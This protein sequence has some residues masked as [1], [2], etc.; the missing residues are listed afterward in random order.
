MTR[1][2]TKS[3]PKTVKFSLPSA[4]VERLRNAVHHLQGPPKLLRMNS[5][6]TEALEAYVGELEEE[7]GGPFPRRPAGAGRARV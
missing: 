1:R 4:L 5:A 6:A 3:T 7:H 2:R